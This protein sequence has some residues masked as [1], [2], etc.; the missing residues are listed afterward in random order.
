MEMKQKFILTEKYCSRCLNG[1]Q[2]DVSW[3]G[4]TAVEFET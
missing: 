3:L 1:L 2:Y 4:R